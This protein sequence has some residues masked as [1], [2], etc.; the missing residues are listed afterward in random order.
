MVLVSQP[1]FTPR[2]VPADSAPTWI[3]L[4]RDLVRRSPALVLAMMVAGGVAGGAPA[5]FFD[6]VGKT[7]GPWALVLAAVVLVAL[8]GLVHTMVTVG[9]LTAALLDRRLDDLPSL[10]RA[11]LETMDPGSWWF[12]IIRRAAATSVIGSRRLLFSVG[13]AVSAYALVQALV[14][15]TVGPPPPPPPVSLAP[16]VHAIAALLLGRL[17]LVNALAATLVAHAGLPL[18]A[19]DR[20]LALRLAA[21]AIRL[22][23]RPMRHLATPVSLCL[24]VL[25][26]SAAVGLVVIGV[27]MPL[28][29]IIVYVAYRDVFLGERENQRVVTLVAAPVPAGAWAPAPAR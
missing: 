25:M 19:G 3:R 17:F 28:F 26:S 22:N 15:P 4:A 5:L 24:V 18:E 9:V 13:C 20:S 6:A 16:L 12:A 14:P 1:V 27:M 21:L 10:G 2:I 7:R 23:Q 8:Q 11:P 29:G